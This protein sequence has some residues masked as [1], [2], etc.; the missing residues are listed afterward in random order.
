[1]PGWA[2][3]AAITDPAGGV[4]I[5]G[6]GN[7]RVRGRPANAPLGAR[8]P[9]S[10]ESHETLSIPGPEPKLRA[11]DFEVAGRPGE[12]RIPRPPGCPAAS[13]QAVQGPGQ[14]GHR[15]RGAR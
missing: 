12:P 8:R 5:S 1:M 11:M 10:A 4:L 15:V 13:E 2:P 3:E 9:R 7:N 14:P 6:T